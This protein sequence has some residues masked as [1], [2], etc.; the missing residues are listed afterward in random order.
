[1]VVIKI[2]PLT[3]AYMEA[4]HLPASVLI[5]LV[6]PMPDRIMDALSRLSSQPKPQLR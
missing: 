1:M 4:N 6:G 5:G 2:T 3:S